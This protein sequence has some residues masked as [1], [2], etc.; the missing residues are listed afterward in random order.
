MLL[1]HVLYAC[2]SK[3]ATTTTMCKG[4]MYAIS[5]YKYRRSVYRT[6]STFW[7]VKNGCNVRRRFELMHRRARWMIMA[8]N[9][10]RLTSFINLQEDDLWREYSVDGYIVVYSI[11]DRRSF[12]KAADVIAS[13]RQQAKRPSKTL[14][15]PLLVA[16]NK[17][18]LE[19]ARVV[20]KEGQ[21]SRNPTEVYM[22]N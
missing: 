19:R 10:Q 21:R 17:S 15:K 14:N 11:T 6:R 3:Y 12:Q 22:N 2:W 7:I 18:D 5:V 9:I 13:I 1:L 4:E 20:A 8:C 16:G